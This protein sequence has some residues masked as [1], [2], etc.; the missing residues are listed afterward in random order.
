MRSGR[1]NCMTRQT[2]EE[3]EILKALEAMATAK[4]PVA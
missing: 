4:K 2:H 1:S 3:A